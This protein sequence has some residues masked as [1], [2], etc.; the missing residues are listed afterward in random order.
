MP[1]RWVNP[2][3]WGHRRLRVRDHPHKARHRHRLVRA[4]DQRPDRPKDGNPRSSPRRIGDRRR[5]PGHPRAVGGGAAG[6]WSSRPC[7]WPWGCGLERRGRSQHYRQPGDTATDDQLPLADRGHD[8]DPANHLN[9]PANHHGQGQGPQ[10]GRDEVDQRQDRPGRP[11]AQRGTIKYKATSRYRAGTVIAQSRP[12]SAGSCPTAGSPWSSPRPRHRP[13]H[14]RRLRRRGTV[15]RP[16]PTCALTPTP[17]TTTA[18]AAQGM[19]PNT[20]RGPLRVRPPDPFR[21]GPGRRRLGW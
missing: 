2:Q 4:G 6:M 10:A 11:W 19:D 17:R 8:H 3:G 9:G 18:P 13:P 5:H 16:I 20:W 14:R 1:D 15:T 21:P 12:T 7:W